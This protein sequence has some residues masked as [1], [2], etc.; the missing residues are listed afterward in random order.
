[1]DTDDRRRSQDEPP[2]LWTATE[3]RARH[4][5]IEGDRSVDV[6]I[7]GGGIV[8]LSAG[9]VLQEAGLDVAI[10][11]ARRVG[12][13]VTGRS[14]AKVTS[15]HGLKYDFLRCTHGVEAARLYAEAN[16]A[17]VGAILQ[18]SGTMAEHG[19]DVHVERRTAYA[20][21]TEGS[22]VESVRAEVDAAREAGLPARFETALAIPYPVAGA[23]AF[24]GQA[25][26]DAYAY[27]EGLARQFAERGA[28][29]EE[30]VVTDIEDGEDGAPVRVRTHGGR[31]VSAGHVI[32][33]THLP[34]LDRGLYFLRTKPRT[35][36]VLAARLGGSVPPGLLGGMFIAADQPTRSF[37]TFED[38]RGHGLV[39]LGESFT[40]GSRDTTAL[41][42]E[43]E[44]EARERFSIG[45]VTHR[46]TN[47]DFD[48]VDGLP[49]VG[50]VLPGR[51]RVL[52]ATGFGAWGISNGHVAGDIL[53]GAVLGRPSA[54]GELFSTTR[55][56]P[57]A[58]WKK[59]LEE[60]VVSAKSLANRA[61]PGRTIHLDEIAPGEAAVGELNGER[62][63]VSRDPDGT[64]QAVSAICTHMG[65]VVGWNG[66]MRTWDCPCHGSSFSRD[67]KLLHG[68]AVHDLPAIDLDH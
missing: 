57:G 10:L 19:I 45:E 29:F 25:Q 35:H 39:F 66:A 68:P 8:G 36:A 12:R 16:Q 5:P 64:L 7:V 32:V 22:A 31:T 37:R 52:V 46:W 43:L 4:G 30:T 6:A 41:F 47:D 11:E 49:L 65:C 14:T 9:L 26:F 24:D 59:T 51:D 55:F 33:A 44:A 28:V 58:S 56:T 67:G 27:V 21:A 38:E 40:P 18:R 42:S 62:A 61:W 34:F 17:A 13:Q 23:V 48:S 1:M 2:S 54:I 50:P 20:Y 3:P 15:Q 60:A 53:A 63:A